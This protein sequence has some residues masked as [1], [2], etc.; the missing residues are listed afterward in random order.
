MISDNISLQSSALFKI[1]IEPALVEKPTIPHMKALIFSYL[2]PEG[3]GRGIIM[4][5]PRPPP[6]KLFATFFFWGHGGQEGWFFEKKIWLG[7]MS[8]SHVCTDIVF[9]T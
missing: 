1:L 5:A 2:E 6:L 8:A 7:Q 9:M 3:W 4:G